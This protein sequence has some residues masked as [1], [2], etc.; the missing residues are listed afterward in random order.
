MALFCVSFTGFIR[1]VLHLQ[2]D[3]GLFI[4]SLTSQ[5]LAHILN[6]VT[7]VVLSSDTRSETPNSCPVHTNFVT[8]T[9]EVMTHVDASLASRDQALIVPALRLLA[10]ILTKCR[11]PLTGMF[12]KHVV[13]QLEVL[14]YV[15][16]DSFTLP[17]IAVLQAAAR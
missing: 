11:E 3:T 14:A 15:K 6:Y 12:W 1:L 17:I 16:D 9:K 8:V 5:I 13:E 10:T 2:N 4:T 7:P